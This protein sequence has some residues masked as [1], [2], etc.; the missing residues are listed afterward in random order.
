MW[1]ELQ[2]YLS[3]LSAEKL[4]ELFRYQPHSPMLFSTGLFL[5]LFV[6]FY[7]I[8][9]SLQNHHRTRI[10]YVILFSLYFYYKTSGLWFVLLLITA[11]S[12]F[13][14]GRVIYATKDAL[15]KKIWVALSICLN[16]GMLGYF[17]YTNFLYELMIGFWHTIGGVMNEQLLKGLVFEPLDIFLPV[18]ISF[19]TFQS[20]SY[21]ID[22][23]RG[24]VKPVT[25][26]TDYLFFVSFFPGLVAGPIVRAR[27]FIP[28]IYKKPLLTYDRMG[29]ALYLIICGLFKKCIISD[30]IS[31]NFVDR[32]FDAPSLYT[33][34]E[35]LMGIYGYALQIYC[36]FSGY[37]DM[38][39]GIALL[40]G[41]RFNIN[42]D[43]PYQSATITEFWRRWHISLSSWLR[44]YLYIPLGGNRKGKAR[45]YLHLA[46][47]MLLGGLWH[48]AA[49]RFVL[50]GAIHGLALAIHKLMI[51]MFGLKPSGVGMSP[52]KRVI[53]TIFTFHLVCFAWIFF[54]A[55]T[56]QKVGEIFT[57]LFNHFEPGV[58]LQ[59]VTGY[60]MIFILMVTGYIIHFIPKKWDL[61]IQ[62]HITVLPLW[63]KALLLCLAI[64][65]VIQMKSAEIVPFIYFQF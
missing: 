6:G 10:A 2:S 34:V 11:T 40:L 61:K 54:R 12:D 50:W 42:F 43:S 5:F 29:E 16:L 55:D 60:R 31:I 64:F 53:N 3:G 13:F 15:N 24:Q 45:T 41:F 47:T 44:D 36:D 57:Q 28:Q 4:F 23:Y 17:K 46:I 21:T 48:G 19:F 9:N 49:L 33:G 35:N 30:Y 8:Y 37:S 7:I 20:L 25:S 59:F 58:F 26:W 63:A 18:G 14:I 56:M 51:N 62:R 39:I 65:F 52:W 32:I 22:V 38:A 27:D 1:N